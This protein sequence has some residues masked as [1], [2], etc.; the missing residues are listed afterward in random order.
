MDVLGGTTEAAADAVGVTLLVAEPDTATA[1]VIVA[2]AV[3]VAAALTEELGVGHSPALEQ[4][5][6]EE[7][8]FRIVVTGSTAT[9]R[10][11][12]AT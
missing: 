2:T 4:G 6:N 5:A 8:M 11:V 3:G 7:V 12:T 1:G 10:T 9:L